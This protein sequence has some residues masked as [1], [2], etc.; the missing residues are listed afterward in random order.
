[1]SFRNALEILCVAHGHTILAGDN[2]AMPFVAELH[3]P[4]TLKLM[5]RA[6]QEAKEESAGRAPPGGDFNVVMANRIVRAVA[7]GERDLNA[8]KRAALSALSSGA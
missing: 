8:L 4:A 2:S 6:L 1:L 3:D 7:C 5:T